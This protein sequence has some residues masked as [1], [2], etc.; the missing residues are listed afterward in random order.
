MLDTAV[1]PSIPPCVLEDVLNGAPRVQRLEAKAGSASWD[2]ELRE[3]G[4]DYGLWQQSEGELEE[5][6]FAVDLGC[7][8][9]KYQRWHEC[10]P[11][12]KP[13]YAVKCNSSTMILRTLSHLGGCGFD[14]AS[15]AEIDQVLA[16]GVSPDRIIYANPCKSQSDLEYAISRGVM[17]MTFDAEEELDK[18]I[19]AQEQSKGEDGDDDS[20]RVQLVLRLRVPD[21]D[22]YC[23][24][25]EKFGAPIGVCSSLITLC[26]QRN[27]DLVGLSFHCG[28]GCFNA[29][30]YP[31]AIK[32]ARQVFDM[33]ASQGVQI[34][35][36]DIGGGFPGWDGSE[37]P[38]QSGSEDKAWPLPLSLDDVADAAN[39]TLDSLFPAGPDG[40]ALI[41]EP[42]RYLVEASHSLFCRVYATRTV[43]VVAQDSE[44]AAK[45][46]LAYFVGE[47]VYGCFK[48]SVLCGVEW[49]PSPIALVDNPPCDTQTGCCGLCERSQDECIVVGPS[50]A[51]G[52]IVAHMKQGLGEEGCGCLRSGSLLYVSRMGAYTS[53]IA[54]TGASQAR[55]NVFYLVSS[56]T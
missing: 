20:C 29:S 36:I 2:A 50:G 10:F 53:S 35:L 6:F 46:V 34:S 55:K 27:L 18:I 48:D 12:V 11:R 9:Q 15:R 4:R 7:I 32:V 37:C 17:T 52:D 19:E 38:Y 39:D 1:D 41:A 54:S 42:G 26:K 5:A 30:A 49:L 56:P 3:A 8:L 21:S 24:L 13:F 23:P 33:A 45:S 22:S 25:G 28:S 51:A 31:T 44:E 47:G 40:V 16:C 14:C 43:R